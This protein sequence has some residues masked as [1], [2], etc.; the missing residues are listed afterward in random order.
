MQKVLTPLQE[1]FAR[2]SRTLDPFNRKPSSHL[3]WISLGYVVSEP[4]DEPFIGVFNGPQSFASIKEKNTKRCIT[5]RA[6][7]KQQNFKLKVFLLQCVQ[8]LTFYD[9]E[10]HPTKRKRTKLM[11]NLTTSPRKT[12]PSK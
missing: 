6:A 10:Y 9:E 7:P 11:Q 5:L 2:H 4:N 3:N 1:P 12:F 8:L